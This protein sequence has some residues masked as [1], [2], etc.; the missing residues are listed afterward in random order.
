MSYFVLSQREIKKIGI[1]KI[2]RFLLVGIVNAIAGYTLI[3]ALYSLLN[4]NIYLSNLIGYLIG[5]II[6]FILNRNFV[7][8]VGGKIINQFLK[9]IFSFFL[10][11]FLN[12][13]V[14]YISSEFINLNYY[15]ALFIASL[16]YSISFFI[17][18]NFFTF[19]RKFS[20]SF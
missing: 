1:K 16:F 19:K 11:Y 13:F 2:K 15:F 3:I 6:S 10:S 14:F 9:F 12:I 20:K 18:C 17:S 4:L 8:K 7:F 5:L